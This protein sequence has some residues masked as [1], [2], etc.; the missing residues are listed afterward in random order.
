M[1]VSTS[2]TQTPKPATPSRRHRVPARPRTPRSP[3]AGG[4]IGP[5]IRLG[6]Q[7][8]ARD[9]RFQ[10]TMFKLQKSAAKLRH[11]PPAAQKA[12]EAQAA[13]I[14]PTN[15][16]MAGAKAGQVEAM[17]VA[18][19]G[20]PESGSFLA[21]MRAEIQRVLPK[22]LGDTEDFLDGSQQQQL[23]GVMSG[24]VQQQKEAAA[25]GIKSAAAQT[26]DPSQVMGKDVTPL[27]SEAAP[28]PDAIAAAGAMPLPK[29][30]EQI[31]LQQSKQ[32]AD[33][34]LADSKLTA[35]Q[36]HKANDP[37][38][39]AVLSAKL[40]L[41][42]QADHAP[43]GYRLSERKTLAQAAVKAATDERQGL[44]GLAGQRSTRDVMVRLRQVS[45]KERDEARRKEV[46]DAIEKIYSESKQTVDGK[47][48]GLETEITT[49][50]DSGAAA[51]L[52]NMKAYTNRLLD[53]YK[54]IR[55]SGVGGAALWVKDAFLDLP[56]EVK[57]FY[58]AGRTQLMLE[59]DA[60]VVVIA[61]RVETR[62]K[63]AKDEIG[64]GEKRLRD[65]VQS[66]PQ[67]LQAV[68]KA[69]EED[70]KSRFDELRRGVD[71]KKNDLAQKLAQRYKE[72]QDQGDA[73]LKAIQEE[74][75]GLYT[76]VK[77]AVGE[78]VEV[79]R[80]FKERVMGLIKKAEATIDLIVADPIGFLK[81]LLDAVKKGLDQFVA[82]IWTHLKAGFMTWMFGVLTQAGVSL[83]ADFSLPSILQL[84]LQVLG[85]TYDRIRAKAAKLI[86][87]RNV[88][89]LEKAWEILSTLLKGGPAA[90]W[91]QVKEYL[92]DLKAQVVDSLQEWVVSTVIKAAV[93]KLATM[94]NPVG[95]IVQAI[96]TIY[97]TVMFFIENINRILDFV[98]AVL[99][100]VHKIATGAIGDAA[101]WIEKALARTVPIM[102]AFL[103]RLLGLSGLSE[104]VKSVI[105]KIQS[106][107]DK[108]ID[109]LIEKVV[110]GIKKL[111]S[112]RKDGKANTLEDMSPV[113]SVPFKMN[114]M[115]H[116]LSVGKHNNS[117]RIMMASNIAEELYGKAI[118]AKK[119]A[120]GSTYLTSKLDKI[121]KKLA[122]LETNL[123]KK[124]NTPAQKG[125]YEVE[126]QELSQELGDMGAKY[127]LKDI[128]ELKEIR[129]AHERHVEVGDN[130]D[131]DPNWE[132]QLYVLDAV[133]KEKLWFATIQFP[134]DLNKAK[135]I[136]LIGNR[137][138]P[139]VKLIFIRDDGSVGSFT[140]E[141]LKRLNEVSLT[142]FH[143]ELT[144][145]HGNLADKN[146]ANF[147]T[148]FAKFKH[149]EGQA[150]N[151]AGQSAIK[152]ISY[153]RERVA[154]G[155]D[156][157]TLLYRKGFQFRLKVRVA[158]NRLEN[159][160]KLDVAAGRLIQRNL[161]PQIVPDAIIFFAPGLPEEVDVQ[162]K[163]TYKPA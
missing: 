68:G 159:G 64:K 32:D 118:Q 55:Y 107:V 43:V 121:I 97:N 148:E 48:A 155:F 66:L 138:K 93:T 23:K 4:A 102:I 70:I 141:S 9:P 129:Y 89:M 21:L 42:K 80:K 98:E 145:I 62:L 158:E 26:P 101:N 17:N 52:E 57:V 33:Q 35:P 54:A 41:G 75:K 10:R 69:A 79:L 128:E 82:N 114:G 74:N 34:L 105:M 122:Q 115:D 11:H 3:A 161:A 123:N 160:M 139:G 136:M 67:D 133:S 156:Q 63:E 29:T 140:G 108:A 144:E 25:G 85:L 116:T 38:F 131:K 60:M 78:V 20:K 103:A 143:K 135:P 142:R 51:A 28:S 112:G 99:N 151:P 47:L 147:Q 90:L 19:A 36:L 56:E 12:V 106:K 71:D 61:D 96:L 30:D 109:K 13:A 24:N 31:S 149:I 27:P 44:L 150:D 73:A 45:A 84:V 127:A 53:D 15:E 65:Y 100:S 6:N 18:E 152:K 104:K 125:K 37:R 39:S 162:V 132:I 92:G 22:T 154:R 50:F 153:G 120:G 124:D 113:M 49:L 72:A 88:A 58:E 46:A 2:R 77:E 81:N 7:S 163:G 91:E 94:F 14:P 134:K 111:V 95:A 1:P 16:K 119:A 59:L 157:F 40:S 83:P 86:G 137:P 87:E 8:V 146:L 5:A 76:K 110:A 126:L 130:V 117:L